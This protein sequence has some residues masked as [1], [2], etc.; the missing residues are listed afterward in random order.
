MNSPPQARRLLRAVTGV[1]VIGAMLVCAFPASAAQPA[2]R[3]AVA[4]AGAVGA[5]QHGL[6]ALVP[7]TRIQASATRTARVLGGKA[8]AADVLPASVD[9]SGYDV[10]VGDQGN[11][12]SCASWAI[13]YAMAGWYAAYQH[14]AGSPFAP[15]YLYSQVGFGQLGGSYANDNYTTWET[16]GIAEHAAYTGTA[17][18]LSWSVKPTAAQV[19]NAAGHKGVGHA[20]LSAGTAQGGSLRTAIQTALASNKPVAIGLPVYGAFDSLTAARSVLTLAMVTGAS[21]GGHEVLAVGYNSAGLVI[22]NS[23]SAWWGNQGYAT[24]SW[25]FVDKYVFEASVGSGFASS[26]ATPTVAKVTKPGVS[27]GTQPSLSDTAGGALTVTGTALASLDLTSPTAVTLVS[28]TSPTVSVRATAVRTDASTLTVTAPAAPKDVTGKPVDGS[29]RVVLTGSAGAGAANSP[30]DTFTY[31]WTVD[32]ASLS[33]AIVAPTGGTV[34]VTGTGFGASAADFARSGITTQVNGATAGGATWL[35]PTTATVTVPAGQ[36]GTAVKVGFLRTVTGQPALAG[37]TATNGRY[38]LAVASMTGGPL[39]STKGGAVVTLTGTG[40]PTASNWRLLTATGSVA[41]SVPIAASLDAARSAGSGVVRTATGVSVVLPAL[42]AGVYKFLFTPDQTG[43]PGASAAVSDAGTLTYVAPFA[44]TGNATTPLSPLG[45]QVAVTSTGF[46]TTAAAFAENKVTATINGTAV[47]TAWVND[48]TITVL[49]P[50]LPLGSAPKLV[51]SK[52]GIPSDAVTLG[53]VAALISTSTLPISPT[54]GG[55]TGVVTG[56]GFA[57]S[58]GW[59]L[60]DSS[61]TK[62]VSLAALSS[63]A[64]L[65]AATSGVLLTSDTTATV[66]LPAAPNG[67]PGVYRLVFTSPS[68]AGSYVPMAFTARSVVIFSDLG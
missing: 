56:K 18:E 39:V 17:G 26:A 64:A 63:A 60:A 61:G 40:V 3:P 6:G 20:F 2:T 8:R 57:G 14:Q 52:S 22:Q 13:G 37:T 66:K 67:A 30:A 53:T 35:S 42:P 25:D 59:A 4:V 10:P 36:A 5:G 48:T 54:A 44:L 55:V 29:Y 1:G 51:V 41:V 21:R 16:Q 33:P 62:V 49:L 11:V 65:A 12:G 24:L 28:T 32:A 27:A 7:T 34:T 45:Q 15:M 43:Y 9:L 47:P 58:T 23:W 31:T 19:A 50:M 38:G 46:G 68:V